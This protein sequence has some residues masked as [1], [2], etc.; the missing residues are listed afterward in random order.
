MLAFG[1]QAKTPMPLPR[2]IRIGEML[3]S[4][5]LLTQDQLAQALEDQKRTGR[6]LGRVLIESGAIEESRL[7]TMLAEQLGIDYVDLRRAAVDRAAAKRLP[8]QLARRFRALVLGPSI[9]GGLR[10]GMADPTDLQAYDELSRHLRADIEVVALAESQLLAV[11]DRV[12]EASDELADL[13]RELKAELAP[14]NSLLTQIAGSGPDDTTPVAR[15]LAGVF[16]DAVKARASDVHFEPQSDHLQVRFRIDGALHNHTRFDSEIAGALAL[17]LK[18]ISHLDI[19]EKRLP[20]DGRFEV[21]VRGQTVDMRISVMPSHW[22]ESVVLRLL[23]STAELPTLERVAMPPR[24]EAQLRGAIARGRGMIVVTGPTG[25]GKTTT[26]YAALNALRSEERKLVTVEDPIEF[27]LPGITQVQVNEKIELSFSRVLR[28][29]L[30]HDPDVVMVGEMRDRETAEIG[31]RAAMTGHL[32]LSTLHTNDAPASPAR[33]IDMGVPAYML[34][35]SLQLVLAQ[36]LVRRLCA[37]CAVDTPPTPQEHAWLLEVTGNA[38]GVATKSAPGCPHCSGTGY[39]GRLPVYESLE[40]TR[41]I[42]DALARDDTE[43]Y[44][45]EARAQ[46]DG[47]RLVHDVARLVAAGRTSVQEAMK[48]AALDAEDL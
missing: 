48:V 43:G 38:D 18:L 4:A 21:S 30:R 42:A 45:R 33:L 41:P 2:R 3:V 44:L 11:L 27:R 25:S 37:H 7:A 40:I 31:V 26:L 12:Y 47:A 22:G 23:N 14:D 28:S 1:L 10:V 15:L 5:G 17:R 13:A 46:L 35:T 24:V 8:E 39:L 36:R 34:A 6:R 20:Q 29:V 32:V 16:E 19:A 9:T